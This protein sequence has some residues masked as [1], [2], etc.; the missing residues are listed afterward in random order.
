MI[1][2]PDGMAD[3]VVAPPEQIVPGLAVAFSFTTDFS[4]RSMGI[5]VVHKLP[6]VIVQ[7]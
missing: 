2:P 1:K 4:V 7:V 3:K 5:T 6:S